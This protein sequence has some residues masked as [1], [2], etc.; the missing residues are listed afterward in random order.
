MSKE[1]TPS[2]KR[3]LQA[4]LTYGPMIS[5]RPWPGSRRGFQSRVQW[6]LVDNGY[7]VNKKIPMHGLEIPHYYLTDKG[8]AELG[9]G[10]EKSLRETLNGFIFLSE[11][12]ENLK[13]AI[14]ANPA[15]VSGDDRVDNPSNLI[16]TAKMVLDRMADDRR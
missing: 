11:S 4:L 15:Y 12:A 3:V 6:F 7:I 13:A 2:R 1:I 14:L 10:A 8:R 5:L 16:H 9:L